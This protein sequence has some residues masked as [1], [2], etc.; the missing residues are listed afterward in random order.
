MNYKTVELS[1][2][3]RG[4][5]F[6]YY[7][8]SMRIVMSLT[9][10]VD[11]TG[12]LSFSKDR[13]LKFYPVMI[14]AVSKIVNAHDEFKYGWDAAGNLIK[15][16]LVSPSYTDFHAQDERFTKLLTPYSDDLPEFHARFMADREKYQDCRA[17]VKNQPSNFFDVSCL[18]WV[19]YRHFDVHVFDEGKFLAPVVTWG[20]Y[21]RENGKYIMPV[22][23]NIHHAVADGFHLS[24]FFAEL[25]ELI[26]SSA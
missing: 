23:M 8:N 7:I 3:S 19:R 10:D 11:V 2:W 16:D 20:K 6:Q 24:R 13:R 17:F 12:L 15:W 4:D 25:Q 5:L 21:E 1:R 26:A 9:A 22:M 14:W 18:P